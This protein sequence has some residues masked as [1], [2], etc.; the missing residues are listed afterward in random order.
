MSHEKTDYCLRESK[1]LVDKCDLFFGGKLHWI[2]CGFGGG[3]PINI[4]KLY[5]NRLHAA[6]SANILYNE[7]LLVDH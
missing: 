3:E 1:T 6:L 7:T 2:Y 4:N 5:Y